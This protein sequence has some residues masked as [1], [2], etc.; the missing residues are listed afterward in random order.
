MFTEKLSGIES[1]YWNSC[2]LCIDF[3][4]L[5]STSSTHF[6]KKKYLKSMETLFILLKTLYFSKYSTFA[7]LFP[8]LVI[9]ESRRSWLK[10]NPQVYDFLTCLYFNLKMQIVWYLVKERR[11]YIETWSIVGIVLEEKFQ[12]KK[13][14][15]IW[16]QK[17]VLDNYLVLIRSCKCSY[18]I[19]ET[20]ENEI[21]WKGTIKILE[22]IWA[23]TLICFSWAHQYLSEGMVFSR[24]LDGL[25][26]G[27]CI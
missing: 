17:V 4:Y 15:E 6:T 26:C 21:F 9:A 27:A 20:L 25:L 23:W 3:I 8:Q 13:Y 18:C 10:I 19:G 22:E 5:G 11:S 12:E 2:N 1:M 16:Y 7:L 14:V 24:L